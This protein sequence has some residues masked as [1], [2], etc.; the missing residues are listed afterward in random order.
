MEGQKD[1]VL[2][3]PDTWDVQVHDMARYNLPAI[4]VKQVR[5]PCDL[6]GH[7]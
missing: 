2:R 3:F 1:L 4:D 6:C 7:G 5:P